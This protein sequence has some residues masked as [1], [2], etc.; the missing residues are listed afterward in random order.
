MDNNLY[1]PSMSFTEILPAVAGITLLYVT[2][3]FLVA[4]W[5]ER[6]DVAD[7]AWGMGIVLLS[8]VSLAVGAAQGIRPLLVTAMVAA[9]GVRLAWHIHYRNRGRNEDFRYRQWREQWGRH[10]LVRSYL[11]IF[12]LQGALMA[13]VAM[14]V[15][16]INTRNNPD[17]RAGDAFGLLL[18]L[19]GF[20]FETV[21]DWQLLRFSGN[22]DHKGLIMTSGLWRYTRHPNYFGEVLLWWGVFVLAAQVPQGWLT[23]LGPLT[24]TVLILKVSGI[25]ML[26][27]KYVN[28]APYQ[29]Y[30]QR[31]SAFLP[32]PPR[33]I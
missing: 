19:L 6:N 23:V 26:E 10:F 3:W 9:W 16:F 31:T 33:S 18:W 14:P 12:V 8:L 30:R 5:R 22:P 27:A 24:I 11:Q 13:V 17:L 20:A 4:L 21:G 29:A 7:V 32:L 25:P 28:N 1:S 15:I 2:L